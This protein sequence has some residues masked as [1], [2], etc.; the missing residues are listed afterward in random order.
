[1]AFPSTWPSLGPLF[2]LLL[3]Q[4]TS[5][6]PKIQA[7]TFLIWILIM[8]FFQIICFILTLIIMA[9]IMLIQKVWLLRDMRIR[10]FRF[11]FRFR[12]D[13][14]KSLVQMRPLLTF[15]SFGRFIFNSG[16][17]DF[18]WRK[19]ERLNLKSSPK[20]KAL[21]GY[22]KALKCFHQKGFKGQHQNNAFIFICPTHS[23]L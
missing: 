23:L 6:A 18:T 16:Y 19:N 15:T 2:F 20:I 3:S 1:M 5:L 13:V 14:A 12:W 10:T 8:N 22:Y 21:K 9:Y 4:A 17:V 7:P 11:T